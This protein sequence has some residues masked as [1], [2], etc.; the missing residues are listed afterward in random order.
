M[1]HQTA[2]SQPAAKTAERLFF[3]PW[4]RQF[5]RLITPFEEFIHRQTTSGIVLLIATLIA[6]GLANSPP[7]RGLRPPRPHDLCPLPGAPGSSPKTWPT[8]STRD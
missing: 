2:R 1:T 8:E 5:E 6:L 7:G 3:Y 4:E